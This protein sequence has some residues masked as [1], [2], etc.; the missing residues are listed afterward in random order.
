MLRLNFI[1][2]LAK[3]ICI[4]ATH[5]SRQQIQ[6]TVCPKKPLKISNIQP[7]VYFPIQTHNGNHSEELN[8]VISVRGDTEIQKENTEKEGKTHR[9]IYGNYSG[10]VVRHLTC[11]KCLSLCGPLPLIPLDSENHIYRKTIRIILG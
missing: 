3:E 10:E 6:W 1:I 7:L 11:D 4:L 9:K 8:C 5:C 2:L